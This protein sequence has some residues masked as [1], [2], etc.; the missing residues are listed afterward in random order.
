MQCPQI[1]AH[2][3]TTLLHYVYC[4]T[5]EESDNV[6]DFSDE[7]NTCIGQNEVTAMVTVNT[8]RLVT[9]ANPEASLLHTMRY[10]YITTQHDVIRV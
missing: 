10:I 5:F 3:D 8:F 6:G 1:F 2:N 7:A 4:Y 9:D